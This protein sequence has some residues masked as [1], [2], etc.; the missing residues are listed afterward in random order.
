MDDLKIRAWQKDAL[1][2][3]YDSALWRRDAFGDTIAFAASGNSHSDHGW[4][5]D[6]SVPVAAGGSD[7]ISNLRPLHWRANVAR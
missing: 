3:G 7:L 6:Q 2:P 4:D 5:I 1:I